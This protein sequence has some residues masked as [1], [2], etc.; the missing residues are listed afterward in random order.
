[1][2]LIDKSMPESCRKCDFCV[3]HESYH[4]VRKISICTA[5]QKPIFNEV[6]DCDLIQNDC[7][8]L[9]EI[10]EGVTNGDVLEKLFPNMNW[11]L[12]LRG[13][14]QDWWDKPFSM[15]GRK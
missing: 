4:I 12:S 10:K 1:M 6:I 9:A 8:I 7:P 11:K 15:E 3:C 13:F 2:L 14:R 5:S